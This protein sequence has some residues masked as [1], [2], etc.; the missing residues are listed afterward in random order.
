MRLIL[1]SL[2]ALLALACDQTIRV[3]H[4]EL[5]IT[6]VTVINGTGGPPAAGRTLL[7][8]DG[9]IA[10][11]APAER[12]AVPA[13]A[14]VVDG[15]GK[16]LIP[17]L[18]DMHVHAW[19][20]SPFSEIFLRQG[21]TA[22][23]E[24]GT[25]MEPMWGG[26]AGVWEWRRAVR[27]GE[28]LGPRVYAAGF[29]LNGGE[30]AGQGAPFFKAAPTPETGREWV[31]TLADNGAD[32][33]KVYSALAPDTFTAIADRAAERGLTLAGHVPARVGTRQAS[34]RMRSLEH[35]Y[36]FLVA[37]SRDE[38]AIRAEIEQEIL[39]SE[40]ASGAAQIAE[41][42]RIDQ[43][44]ATQDPV[45]AAELFELLAAN[46]TWLSPTL[47]V[48]ADARCPDA[49]L[50]L[51]DEQALAGVPG[52]LHRFVQYPEVD[53]EELD[54]RCRRFRALRPL[55]AAADLA[56]VDL[57]AGSDSPNPGAV[58]GVGL[59]DE[60]ALLVDA[61]LTPARVLEI[62]TRDAAR[63]MG[64]GETLGT[65]EIGK[66]ADMVLLGANPLID[67]ANTRRVEAVFI[68]GRNALEE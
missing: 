34:A 63:F 65:L 42:S 35:L 32:F 36:D 68:A 40:T 55:V 46:G 31:D 67:I 25:G 2:C 23:R 56:G 37:A 33:I 22:V 12:V 39:T 47:V 15:A 43:L 57:L 27:E 51:A 26:S 14:R 52:F 48:S 50:A 66:I 21:I 28:R 64:E 18:W 29:I 24:M 38:E 3:D 9:R 8:A 54:R 13:G 11:I 41:R 16:F 30:Q 62:A 6:D 19:S 44:I 58:P 7:V 59:H 20:P 53:Q 45:R 5:A 1:V 17:G 49:P 60:L 10:A 4:A 61:G